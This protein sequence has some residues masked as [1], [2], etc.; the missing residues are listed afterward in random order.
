ME[1]EIKALLERLARG[2]LDHSRLADGAEYRSLLAGHLARL[3]SLTFHPS[4]DP[5]QIL[6]ALPRE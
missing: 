3:R 2:T 5:D 4:D 1:T 6:G